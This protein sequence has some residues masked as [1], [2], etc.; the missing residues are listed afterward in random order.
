[1]S[2]DANSKPIFI[3]GVGAQ[4]AGTSWLHQCLQAQ[5][6]V[7][8][9][10]TKEYHVW[11]GLFCDDFKKFRLDDTEVSDNTKKTIRYAMQRY[12]GFYERYFAS[13]IKNNVRITGDITPGYAALSADHLQHVRSRLEQ[14]GFQVKVIFILRDP[15]ARCWSAARMEMGR[16]IDSGQQITT[17]DANRFFAEYYTEPMVQ[18]RTRYELTLANL[19]TTFDEHACFCS[20]YE[21]LF[22]PSVL[23][24]LSSFL[25]VKLS[26]GHRE[27]TV[28]PSPRFE[29][30]ASLAGDCAAFYGDTYIHCR[31][32]F[33]DTETL[34]GHL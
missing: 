31:E 26:T 32:A 21:H 11:D 17:D 3:L 29:L 2:D 13:L 1:M 5:P 4:K 24:S 10:F 22:N 16:L 28:N 20:L 25:G 15:V 23:D 34:W 14:A 27:D 8:L 9:G 6:E 33:P 7:D 12:E 18:A 30:E 19:S